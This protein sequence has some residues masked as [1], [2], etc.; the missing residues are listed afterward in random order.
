M[1]LVSPDVV[2]GDNRTRSQRHNYS[3]DQL[4]LLNFIFDEIRYPS[5]PQKDELAEIMSITR[6]QIKVTIIYFIP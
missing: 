4:E 6:D 3:R 2:D 5:N 1:F